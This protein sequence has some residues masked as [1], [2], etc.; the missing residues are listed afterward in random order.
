[1]IQ[2]LT[3]SVPLDESFAYKLYAKGLQ[4]DVPRQK[5]IHET[6]YSFWGDK[7][8]V[9]F[10]YFGELKRA[11]IIS[12]W[13]GVG[14]KSNLPGVEEDVVILLS[15]KGTAFRTLD[16]MLKVLCRINEIATFKMPRIFW[17]KFATLVRLN[18]AKKSTVINL[19]NSFIGE[20]R[21]NERKKNICS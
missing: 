14:E 9:L 11:Y 20:K 18:K 12:R 7:P 6:V 17:Y 5:N 8:V 3:I 2:K 16:R 4:I 15:A 1:M 19:Y 21:K 13:K 10:Y